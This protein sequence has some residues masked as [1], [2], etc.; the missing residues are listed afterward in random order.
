MEVVRKNMD[1]I[2]CAYRGEH[3]A[4]SF[5][6]YSHERDTRNF[7]VRA[8]WENGYLLVRGV[9]FTLHFFPKSTIRDI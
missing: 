6:S 4:F 7:T 8:A 9:L 2:T 1:E 3:L 5:G